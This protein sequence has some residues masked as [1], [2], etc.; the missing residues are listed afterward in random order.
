MIMPH[1]QGKLPHI[2][3]AQEISLFQQS[4]LWA[5]FSLQIIKSTPSIKH[6]IL[7][8]M[9]MCKKNTVQQAG[10]MLNGSEKEQS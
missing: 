6:S 7:N 1:T 9:S 4:P 2:T 3:K 10:I 8:C 5:L